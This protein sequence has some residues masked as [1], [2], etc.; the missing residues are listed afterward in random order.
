MVNSQYIMF[1]DDIFVS[2]KYL[3]EVFSLLISTM[4]QYLSNL[5]KHN[6]RSV[7]DDIRLYV[8]QNIQKVLFAKNAKINN[9]FN[10]VF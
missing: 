6:V 7:T 5:I 3:K 1:H 10:V 8:T 2:T 4:C 9:L